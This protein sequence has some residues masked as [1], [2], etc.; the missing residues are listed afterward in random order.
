MVNL[1]L[2]DDESEI[3]DYAIYVD[4]HDHSKR[5]F[6]MGLLKDHVMDNILKIP[7]IANLDD[8]EILIFIERHR[9]ERYEQ[10]RSFTSE[11][12]FK[13]IIEESKMFDSLDDY[14]IKKK[15][16]LGTGGEIDE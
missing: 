8:D 9:I 10:M 1:R 4:S 3:L 5:T 12:Q 13:R 7:S 14:E 11:E 6:L 2:S 16:L 15:K